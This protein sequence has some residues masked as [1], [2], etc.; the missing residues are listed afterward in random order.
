MALTEVVVGGI[1]ERLLPVLRDLDRD[2]KVGPLT[3]AILVPSQIY[4]SF[5]SLI[6]SSVGF[7]SMRLSEATAFVLSKLHD[8]PGGLSQD[9]ET[10][11][12]LRTNSPTVRIL[13][14]SHNVP[15]LGT[16]YRDL[17]LPSLAAGLDGAIILLARPL[18][19]AA[20]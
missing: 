15:E 12:I 6:V 9:I 10:V 17:G 7:D 4:D 11:S 20:A 13:S 2:S 18:H 19:V 8:Q 16:A 1:Y 14:E 5:Q 3:L